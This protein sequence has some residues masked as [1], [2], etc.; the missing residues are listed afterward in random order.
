MVLIGVVMPSCVG[1]DH[2]AADGIL[3]T[4]ACHRIHSLSMFNLCFAASNSTAPGIE[5][6]VDRG[7]Y[8]TGNKTVEK[9]F[10]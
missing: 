4:S 3:H 2:H 6:V 1:I 5:S 9:C 7:E 10:N 8:D